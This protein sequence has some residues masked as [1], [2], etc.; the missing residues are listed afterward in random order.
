MHASMRFELLD[1]LFNVETYYTWEETMITRS[2][3]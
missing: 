3:T 2:E 1:G